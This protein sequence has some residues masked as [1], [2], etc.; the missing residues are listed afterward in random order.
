[1][2]AINF[3]SNSISAST[4]SG[5]SSF[6]WQKPNNNAKI[7]DKTV[8]SE[9]P[10]PKMSL[11]MKKLKAIKGACVLI[12]RTR[13]E[14]LV[15]Y[16]EALITICKAM[17]TK[18]YGKSAVYLQLFN[19]GVVHNKEQIITGYPIDGAM[20]SLGGSRVW[21][22]LVVCL[23]TRNNT[24]VARCILVTLLHCGTPE[25][26]IIAIYIVSSVGTSLSTFSQ[27]YERYT[28]GRGQIAIHTFLDIIIQM[29]IE[30]FTYGNH[31]LKKKKD[32]NYKLREWKRKLS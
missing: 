20:S 12:S 28:R 9:P 21:K 23:H 22:I 3:Q 24:I 13:F 6:S 31:F 8:S 15:T 32:C 27:A 10:A 16:H 2:N 17:K 18:M 5:S 30:H 26:C 11:A 4:A 19:L 14:L 7:L 25:T 29:L 1:M